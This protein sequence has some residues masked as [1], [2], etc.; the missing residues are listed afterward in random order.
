MLLALEAPPGNPE[1]RLLSSCGIPGLNIEVQL[2]DDNNLD[3]ATGE[4]GEVIVRAPNVI[5]GYWNLPQETAHA[6]QGGW[7]HTGDLAIKDERSYFYIVDRK[8]DIVISGGENVYSADVENALYSHPAV[9]E[10]AVIGVPDPKWGERVHAVVVLK[11]GYT[12]IEVELIAR[13]RELISGYKV[14]KSIEFVS[15]MPKSGA[16]KILKQNLRQKY[17]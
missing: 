1:A 9:L 7:L 4:I 13:C 17:W 11:D 8:K 14:W 15:E 3:V 2:V 12:A 6:L 16:G 5:K 10:A